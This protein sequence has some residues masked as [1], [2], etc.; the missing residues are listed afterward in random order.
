[1]ECHHPNQAKDLRHRDVE[2]P[3]IVLDAFFRLDRWRAE[4]APAHRRFALDPDAAKF[5]GWTVEQAASV[6][7]SHYHDVIPRFARDWDE[8]TRYS[9]AIRRCS[10]GQA[11][12]SVELRSI[13]R[14][15]DASYMIAP[16]L[17]GQGLASRAL[18]AMIAWAT[19]QLGLRRVNLACHVD[20]T[21]L[22][23]GR[24]E[25]RLRLRLPRGQR[26]PLP[27]RHDAGVTDIAAVTRITNR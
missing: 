1:L 27:T 6:A 12:G 20:N 8:G 2:S 3:V 9:L 14:E 7:D 16:E 21:G 10:D 17:R 23:A 24:R 26:A 18:V 25:V 4:D 11:V 19:R 15:A 13:G 5:F 22:S